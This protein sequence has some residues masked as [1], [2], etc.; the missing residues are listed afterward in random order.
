[1]NTYKTR[2]LLALSGYG[3]IVGAVIAA[4]LYQFFPS[5]NWT[6]YIVVFAFFLIVESLIVNMV[7]NNSN[8][9]NNRALVNIYMLSKALKVVLSLVLVLIYF[10]IERSYNLKIFA[11]V[12]V[13]FY[14]LFLV[15][16]TYM[17]SKIEKRIKKDN[18]NE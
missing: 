10:L 2:L 1:M 5:F 9:K 16:E 8:S 3:L 7:V 18:N 12:L 11:V 14:F 6:W 4:V 15:A 13:A 17:L